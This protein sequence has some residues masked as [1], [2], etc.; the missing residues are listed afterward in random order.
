TLPP[1][2]AV[3]PTGLFFTAV[4]GG[5]QTGWQTISI[6]NDGDG[7]MTWSAAID[8]SWILASSLEGTAPTDI[9]IAVDPTDLSAGE[10]TGSITFSAS[11]ATNSPQNI[12]VTL[13]VR[14]PYAVYLPLIL[15]HPS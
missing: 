10:Y 5:G 14:E 3:A 12:R 2:L 7:T 1:K 15:Q 6:R 9:S 8:Q 4:E 13:Y 11:G